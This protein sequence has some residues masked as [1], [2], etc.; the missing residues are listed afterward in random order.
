V[1]E[2]VHL[3]SRMAIAG[4]PLDEDFDEFRDI[5]VR[6]LLHD[7]EAGPHKPKEVIE[8]AIERTGRYLYSRHAD[9]YASGVLA[10]EKGALQRKVD[11]VVAVLRML[12]APELA[13]LTSIQVV[14]EAL[15]KALELPA[16][17]TV[18]GV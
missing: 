4:W 11:S 10:S 3:L 1:T 7:W 15:R 8:A 14:V 6:F 16:P 13:S 12:E 17:P 5:A 9:Y 18:G 2:P